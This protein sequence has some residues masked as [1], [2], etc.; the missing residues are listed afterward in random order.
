MRLGLSESDILIFTLERLDVRKVFIE[1]ARSF[2]HT[3]A[4]SR[5]MYFKITNGLSR[6]LNKQY[7]KAGGF[8]RK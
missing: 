4:D 2:G 8:I 3:F 7:K 6:E 5:R 1:E